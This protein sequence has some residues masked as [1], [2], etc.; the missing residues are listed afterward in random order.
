MLKRHVGDVIFFRRDKACRV[1]KDAAFRLLDN[2]EALERGGRKLNIGQRL[3]AETEGIGAAVLDDLNRQRETMQ[4]ARAKVI[5]DFG[6]IFNVDEMRI[7]KSFFLE[8]GRQP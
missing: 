8:N 5:S 7:S 1:T 4:H 6:S 3:L 2:N